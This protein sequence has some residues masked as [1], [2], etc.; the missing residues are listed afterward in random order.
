MLGGGEHRML[1]ARGR[2]R[3]RRE[4]A[5]GRKEHTR[6]ECRLRE[7]AEIA[8]LP[9]GDA[10]QNDSRQSSMLLGC[11]ALGPDRASSEPQTRPH[12][13]IGMCM[14]DGAQ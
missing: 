2:R 8:L 10:A 7:G 12:T 9:R 3:K 14:C 13:A 5:H 6:M 4:D 11:W 1:V